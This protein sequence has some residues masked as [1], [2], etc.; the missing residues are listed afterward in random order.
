MPSWFDMSNLPLPPELYLSKVV[1]DDESVKNGVQIIDDLVQAE[2]KAGIPESRIV[3]GGFS[4]GGALA[5]AA[6]LGGKDW[7]TKSS[8]DESKLAGVVVLSGWMP[9]REKFKSVSSNA[10]S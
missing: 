2:V 10:P 4:Q 1:D 3:V 5:L 9:V 7:R 8:G 6:G